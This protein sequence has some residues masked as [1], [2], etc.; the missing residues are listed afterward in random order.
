MKLEIIFM[1]KDQKYCLTQFTE[2]IKA[3]FVKFFWKSVKVK[4]KIKQQ[5]IIY[6]SRFI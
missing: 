1:T 6:N 5:K 2:A 3:I 4:L